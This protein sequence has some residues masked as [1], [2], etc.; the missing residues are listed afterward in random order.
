MKTT[1]RF[2]FI[3]LALLA[4]VHPAL[5]QPSLG[6]VPTNNQALLY[7][8]PTATNYVLQSS[9]NLA[10]TNWV[11]ATDAV[12]ATYGSQTAVT[13]TNTLA[14]RFF[15]LI[16]VPTATAGGMA[17]IPAGEFTIGNSIGDSDIFDA[18][19]T[20]VYV[21]AYYMDTNLVSLSQWQGVYSYAT[22]HGYS[23]VNAG[24]DK[25][26][27]T[28]VETVDW[29]D[30]VKWS[31]ARSQQASLT[32]VYYRN[33]GFT[34][35][36]TN[37][38]TNTTVYANWGANGYRLPTEA[39]WEKAARGGLSGQR[40]PLGNTISESQA[41]YHGATGIYAYDSGPN[42]YNAIGNYPTDSVGTSPVGSF[43]ANGYGLNDMA[44]NV[45]EWCWDWYA[46]TTYPAGSPYLGGTDPRGPVG[47]LNYRVLRGGLWSDYASI[48]RCAYRFDGIPD[49][50]G[51]YGGFRCVRGL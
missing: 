5:A 48:A 50:A 29:F 32:P 26:A 49:D 45:A 19:P 16:L 9:T 47:P 8:S 10:S 40:F 38:D 41:N 27:N 35:V 22:N 7:W 12:P 37:G 21:S 24:T 33:A 25:A 20:N 39:E 42:G 34:Q 43:S 44:G 2:L 15:R 18:N 23:F 30:C 31:N 11:F 51:S 13:V 14:A 17:L 1:L 36:F 4:G 28:P 46:G 3:G 6:I